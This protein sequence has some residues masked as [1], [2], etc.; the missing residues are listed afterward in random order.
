MGIPLSPNCDIARFGAAPSI[1]SPTDS[2]VSSL[3]S[4]PAYPG[5]RSQS[6]TSSVSA[7]QPGYSDQ[8][9]VSSV[10]LANSVTFNNISDHSREHSRTSRNRERKKELCSIM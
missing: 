4:I 1:L 9:S 3:I 5:Y 8:E 6:D 10:S 2:T 7:L